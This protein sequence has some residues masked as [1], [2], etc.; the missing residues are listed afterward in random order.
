MDILNHDPPQVLWISLEHFQ[1]MQADAIAR[2]PEE[3]CGLVAGREGRT[4]QIF[5]I[6]NT[7]HSPVRFRMDPQEQWH[8]FQQ[9]EAGS[10]ELLA[11]YHS[12]PTGFSSPSR[13]DLA[14]CTYPEVIQLI[15]SPKDG[16]WRCRGYVIQAGRATEVTIESTAERA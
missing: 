4:A 12:H 14:E 16:E 9:I 3:A 11:I 2:M 15:W 1:K 6:T 5:P 13:T 7:L 8:A 10:W